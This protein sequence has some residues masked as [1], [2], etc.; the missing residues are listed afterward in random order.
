MNLENSMLSR[1][2]SVTKVH[3]LRDFIYNKYPIYANPKRQK[4]DWWLPRAERT[5]EKYVVT[6]KVYGDFFADDEKVLNQ[7]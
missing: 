7:W 1:K 2:E 3:I 4:I 6:T 5:V